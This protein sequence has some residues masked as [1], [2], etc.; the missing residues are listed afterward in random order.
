MKNER[1][2]FSMHIYLFSKTMNNDKFVPNMIR[3]IF[4]CLP[5]ILVRNRC[6]LTALT[7]L[8]S[9]LKKG[10]SKLESS[11]VLDSAIKGNGSSWRNC[12]IGF[13]MYCIALSRGSS[14]GTEHHLL[15]AREFCMHVVGCMPPTNQADSIRGLKS[16]CKSTNLQ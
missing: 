14:F 11:Y 10:T 3:T 15:P 6:V 4:G 13:P 16:V 9:Y 12:N 8:G 5:G 1:F 7:T 2:F